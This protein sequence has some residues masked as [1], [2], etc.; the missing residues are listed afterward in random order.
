MMVKLIVSVLLMNQDYVEKIHMGT[1]IIAFVTVIW[2]LV[3][4]VQRKYVLKIIE[5][6]CDEIRNFTGSISI[7]YGYYEYR[8]S[9]HEFFC[10]RLDEVQKPREVSFALGKTKLPKKRKIEQDNNTLI[11]QFPGISTTRQQRCHRGLPL[12]VWLDS[13]TNSSREACLCPPSYYGEA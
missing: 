4:Y 10:T 3:V 9:V 8:T 11:R 13:E 12:Q 5:R 2:A 7:C 6:L 1:K